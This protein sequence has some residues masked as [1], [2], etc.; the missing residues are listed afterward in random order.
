MSLD[1]IGLLLPSHLAELLPP[2]HVVMALLPSRM[3][4]TMCWEIDYRFFG[5]Q[6]KA[7]ENKVKQAQRV[8]VVDQLLKDANRQAEEATETSK[9]E[10][11]PA[12]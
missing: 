12:K 7:Q 6:K 9:K 8:G 4:D 1:S 3:E 10:V 11:A 2:R 5:E